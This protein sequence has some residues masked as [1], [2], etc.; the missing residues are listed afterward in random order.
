MPNLD[1]IPTAAVASIVEQLGQFLATPKADLRKTLGDVD[2]PALAESLA[3]CF[4]SAEQVV[5]PP[6]KLSSLIQPSGYWH[7]QVHTAVGPTHSARSSQQGFESTYFQ[8]EQL[9]QSPIAAKVAEALAWVDQSFPDDDATVRLLVIP[10][11]YVQALLIIR[12]Q[13]YSAVLADQPATFRRLEYRKEYTLRTFLKQLAK[14]Q[15]SG[16]LTA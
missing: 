2:E 12:G 8:V 1:P 11:N 6:A 3:I 10:A 13:K 16:T 7:H 9:V 14:E 5:R 15:V 4:V